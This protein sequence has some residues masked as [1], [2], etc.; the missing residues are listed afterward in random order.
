[1]WVYKAVSRMQATQFL[2]LGRVGHGLIALQ[3]LMVPAQSVSAKTSPQRSRTVG[4]LLKSIES[5]ASQ[6]QINKKKNALPKFSN[7]FAAPPRVNLQSVKPPMSSRLYYE[8]GTNEAELEKVTD[9]LI[10]QAYKLTQQFKTSKRRGELWLR[11]AELYVEKARLI[12]YRLQ[13]KFQQDI[14][15]AEAKK[16]KVRPKLNLRPA[17][18]FNRRA[19]QLY[20]WF[21][22]DFPKD[23]KIDQALFFLGYNYFELGEENKGRG[24]YERLTKE[25]P[26][27]PYV[28]ESNF[29]LGEFHFEKEQWKEALQYYVRV[30]KNPRARLY[31]FSLYK[32]AW[33]YYKSGSV[34]NALASLERVIRAGRV[35]QGKADKSGGVSRIRL[36]TEAMKDLVIF[37]A[38]V[39]TPQG[40][41]RYFDRIAGAKASFTLLEKLAYY[42][43]DTGNRKGAYHLFKELIDIRPGAPKA[44]DYQYQIVSMFAGS[45]DN[46]TFREELY[47]WIS[48]YGPESA[49]QQANAKS[50]ETTAKAT[51]LIELTLRNFILQNH[52]AA[53]NS[54]AVYSQ[55]Q[56]ALGYELYFNT[57]KTSEKMDEMHF[58]FGE[59]LFDMKDY[60]RAAY[61]YSWVTE[62]AKESK[63]R[64][65]AYLNAVLAYEKMLPSIGE[66]K[67]MVADTTDSREFS[68]NVKGF[69]RAATAFLKEAK[70]HENKVAVMYKLGSLHYY[71]NQF[72][73]AIRIF[74]E[75]IEKHP[76][77]QFAEFSANLILDIYNLKKDYEGLETAGRR[78]LAIP[79]LASR[80]VGVEI[81]R[82][83]QQTSFKRAQDFEVGKDY[84]KSAESYEQFI[85]NNPSS[86]LVAQATY[87]A[88]VNYERAG[89]LFKALSL[90]AMVVQSKNPK[91]QSLKKNSTRFVAALYER[92]GQ[93]E[94]AARA[95]EAYARAN[96]KDKDAVSFYYNA[97]VI[98]DGLNRY[99]QALNNYQRFFDLTR[100]R[101]RIEVLFLMAKLWE[102]R[103]NMVRSESYYK[104]FIDANPSD[105]AA[106]VEAAYTIGKFREARGHRTL[107][108]EWFNKAI[109]IQRKVSR[110]DSPVGVSFAAEAK[111]R[112]VSRTYDEFRNIKIPANPAAQAAAVQKKLALLNRLKD[113]LTTVIKY[114]DGFQVVASLV[115][116]GQAYQHMAASLYAAPLPKGL[117]ADGLKQYKQGVDQLA[118]PFEAEAIKNYEFAIEKGS[119]V[120][121][122]NESLK[123]AHRELSRLKDGVDEDLEQRTFLTKVP[124]WMGLGE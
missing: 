76:K 98:F 119:Q 117:D 78:I 61:H 24:Y 46:K 21:L 1:M 69:E 77:T 100:T 96:E 60:E 115:L 15:A 113:E 123:V 45:G 97:A 121:G 8:E 56:A 40:A 26:R 25:H 62:N 11:L 33:C 90:Y 17:Q 94:K 38:E 104:Q 22:R 39:G 91:V 114:D 73:P 42:Y 19:I 107:S 112:L 31:S 120:E 122:Y 10:A 105:A 13:Q 87:N 5:R 16:S 86:D 99:S 30:A 85:K 41:K 83:L 44:Y 57:F 43:V 6:I 89:D 81:R 51:Q 54:K 27:S 34:K 79:E 18:E 82:V 35:A 49:W 80:P 74:N 32:A 71:H 118:K 108:A 111:F 68:K 23:P 37:Y 66:L 92:T 116:I 3:L 9:D 103:G 4:E 70:A 7:Q 67:K 53:Q 106:L 50:P 63:H 110:S 2:R 55:K 102:R 64:E 65:Q 59:L 52:Q 36:A 12:E 93:Y 75:V 48:D 29:A 58:Y 88:A 72:D 47:R 109:A 28:D 124:D 20:E 101:A 95:F 84:L 14:E